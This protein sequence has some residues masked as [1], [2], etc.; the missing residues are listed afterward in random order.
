MRKYS[1]IIAI[2]FVISI[3]VIAYAGHD[4]MVIPYEKQ[5]FGTATSMPI[6][7]GGD[8]RQHIIG[9][10]P[11]K[12][13]KMWPGKD[14]MF[15]GAEPHGSLLTVFVNDNALSSIKKMKGMSNNSIIVKE[16]YAPNKNLVAITVMYKVKGYNPEAGDW[17]WAKY[18]PDWEVL[19][20]GK[21]KG[22]LG[23]H[24][25]AKSN[26]FIFTGKVTK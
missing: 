2:L 21:V 6:P 8:L 16:N 23:C 7:A 17:F 12:N 5:G 4:H 18:G 20:E 19:A 24:T 9:Q 14:K 26:D 1:T 10:E 3:A 25:S 15:K 11:Y 13:W 22:C